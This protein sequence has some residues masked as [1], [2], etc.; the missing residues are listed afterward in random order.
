MDRLSLVKGK[1]LN[2]LDNLYVKHPIPS[3]I[4]NLGENKY[5]EYLSCLLDR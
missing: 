4:E 5:Y 3:E 2:L 1:S